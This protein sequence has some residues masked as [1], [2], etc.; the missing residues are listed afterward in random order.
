[1]INSNVI[2]SR[3]SKLREYLKILKE[4]SKE[5]KAKFISDYRI[6]GL[7]ERYLQ[8][9]IE[10]VL[11]IGNHLISRLE[12]RKPE[13]YQ[14]IL[15]ILG[16]NAIIPKEFAEKLAKAAGFRNILVHD[17]IDIDKNI[18]YEHLIEETTDFERFIEYILKYLQKSD[19][20]F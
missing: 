5:N 7:A 2:N 6:Y 17:Y 14:D 19:A 1:M 10:C 20:K 4:I 11:D 16:E 3:I 9:A 15:L 13:I 8:L 12:L 18:V